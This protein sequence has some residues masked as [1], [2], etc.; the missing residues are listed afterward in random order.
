MKLGRFQEQDI[1]WMIL[2]ENDDEYLL[3]SKDVLMIKPY[4]EEYQNITWKKCTLNRYLNNE[5]KTEC[6]VDS[7]N[8]LEISL[9]SIKQAQKY[10]DSNEQ[11]C[12]CLMNTN[13]YVSYWLIDRGNYPTNASVVFKTGGISIGGYKACDITRG[14][15]VLM[16]VKK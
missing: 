10:F 16:R 6:F 12:A 1:E 11:R 15:R 5:F 2:E 7:S 3:L 14:V 8:I 13:K 4:H 9:L